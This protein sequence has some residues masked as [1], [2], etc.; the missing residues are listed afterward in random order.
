L[1]NLENSL[2]LSTQN[3]KKK[4][5]NSEFSPH[6]NHWESRWEFEWI[7]CSSI[8]NCLEFIG[9]WFETTG[10]PPA[11]SSIPLEKNSQLDSL[12]SPKGK[13]LGVKTG[14]RVDLPKS[15]LELFGFD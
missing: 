15:H 3:Q 4:H 1:K 10:I 11:S 2:A 12:C 9:N 7:C 13:E 8:W 5:L 14:I 6:V